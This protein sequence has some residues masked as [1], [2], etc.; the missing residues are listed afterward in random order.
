MKK[1]FLSV[2]LLMGILSL[3]SSGADSI[4]KG[5]TAMSK[6]NKSF[7]MVKDGV[8]LATI[9]FP[10][11]TEFDRYVKA[12]PEDIDAFAR[13]SFPKASP[14]NLELVKKNLPHAM[15]KEAAR[16]GDE[17][18]LASEELI[19]FIKKI[20]G[21]DLPVKRLEKGE[22]LPSG[23]L[24]LL[25]SELA[26]GEG[27]EKELAVLSPDGFLIRTNGDRLILSG[28]RARG[29]LYAVYELLE[30]LGCRWVMPG[31]FGEIIPE[32][33]NIVVSVDKI[34]NPS[35]RER[36]WW[37]TNGAG[38][39]YPRWTLRNKG[40]YVHALGDPKVRQ[41][42]AS[43]K[44]LDY[45]AKNPDLQIKGRKE[46]SEWK[47]D[48]K[49][50]VLRFENGQPAE[51][52]TVMKEVVQLPDEYYTMVGGKPNMEIANMSN[53]K[54]W[55]LCN[56]YYR[57]YFYKNPLQGY[58]SISAADGLVLDDRAETRSLDSNEYDWTMGALSSTDRLWFFHRRYIENVIQEHPDRKFGVLVYANNMTPPRIETVHPSMALVFAPLGICP[59]H[60]V[61]DENCKTNRAYKT[62]FESWMA[63]AETAGAE[64]YYYDYLPI[65]FQ[66]CNFIMSPQWGIIGK[67]Y[68]WFH[69]L[70]L[71]GHTT[72]GF[73]DSGAMGL[74]AWVAI[75]LYWDINQ[76]YNK[77][78][79][80]Y[81][82]LRFGRKATTA[83][84]DYY[85]VFEKRMDV[86]PDICGNEIWGNHLTIDA[87]TRSKAREALKKAETLIEGEREKRHFQA[88][89]DFQK[90]M[91]AWCD[92]IDY[93]RET[94]DF[95]EAAKKMEPAFE[96]G[97]NLNKIYSHYVNPTRIDKKTR[98]PYT[99]GGWLLKYMSWDK[100]IKGSKANVVLP[101]TMKV[102]LDT[103]NLA[104][105]KGW[106][107]PEVSVAGLEDWD[108][109]VVPDVKYKTDREVAAFFYRTEVEVPESFKG[110]EKVVLYFPSLIARAM[111][112]WI[113]GQPVVFDNGKY[114]DEIWR[115]PAYFW[116]NYYHHREFYVTPYVKP[117]QK[118]TIAFR[119]FKSFDHAGTYDRVFLLANPP[120]DAIKE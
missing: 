53:P 4:V 7:E 118:N 30:T 33:K 18:K 74:T 17:E 49:G 50:Q 35:H 47:R 114:K 83:M 67:N 76:D 46:V 73:D 63:Q 27:L 43:Q 22:A 26:K 66:W 64:S 110:A 85:N 56:E 96:I 92:G 120:K 3:E 119:I 84:H 21:A 79:E 40:N 39:D 6:G 106:H 20:S 59:L 81:C 1:S 115:G 78:V 69:K 60:H 93:A 54:V 37:C 32:T 70:G 29:T 61:R 100:K 102:A 116:N 11:E 98:Q 101:R 9:V 5:E 105:T 99:P 86:V 72:Q 55:D 71:D 51:K 28:C 16:V 88:V 104:F 34:G 52:V 113:N 10:K 75:R 15:K 41:E 108:S 95:A 94:G 12:A 103:D 42:H 44:P 19:A 109:T 62:W 25:G 87:D 24:I 23:K 97:G 36:F 77:L 68:P 112:I 58:V 90:G 45:G 2:A 65:G 82:Q 111:R 91:D 107:K 8:P 13:R 48:E 89:C 57:D 38:A 31:A 80:E 117:G 14:E